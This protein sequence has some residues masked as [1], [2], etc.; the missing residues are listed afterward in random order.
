[1]LVSEIPQHFQKCFTDYDRGT[2]ALK[3]MCEAMG[4]LHSLVFLFRVENVLYEKRENIEYVWY[5]AI[6]FLQSVTICLEK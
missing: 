3:K 2:P 5:Y 1:M 4:L 6:D